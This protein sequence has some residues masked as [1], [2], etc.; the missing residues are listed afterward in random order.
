MAHCT[1]E[2]AWFIKNHERIERV[3]SEWASGESRTNGEHEALIHCTSG[4]LIVS[5]FSGY[6]KIIYKRAK[7]FLRNQFYTV[8]S[9]ESW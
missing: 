1:A 2:N 7:T 6:S 9:N 8:L 4:V 5:N 3:E